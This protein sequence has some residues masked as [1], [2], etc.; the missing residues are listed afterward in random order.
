MARR[1]ITR[2]LYDALLEGFRVKPG[3]ASHAADVA[4]C[5]RRMARRGW[6]QGW[7]RN[8]IWARPIRE[9]I[10]EELQAARAERVRMQEEE[11]E[12]AQGIRDRARADSIKA[13][14]EEAHKILQGMMIS[15][16]PLLGKLKAALSDPNL[17]LKPKEMVR[18]LK[19]TSGVVRQVNEAIKTSLEIERLRLGEPLRGDDVDDDLGNDELLEDLLGIDR[20]LRRAT[21]LASSS[22]LK[23]LED[24]SFV[25]DLPEEAFEEPEA[26]VINLKE[27]SKTR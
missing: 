2:D 11:Q 9:V 18:I 3:N 26:D 7:E 17:Q 6:E 12:H 14:V 5:E 23:I 27:R 8:A 13:N 20:T 10:R 15:T 24:G 25:I 4:G 16:F 19:D 22:P 1:A 21:V